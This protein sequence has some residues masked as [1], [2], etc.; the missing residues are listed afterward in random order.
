MRQ[1]DN[2]QTLF[3]LAREVAKSEGEGITT[4]CVGALAEYLAIVRLLEL[5]HKVA[6]P[7]VDDDG[8]DLWVGYS[9]MIKVQVKSAN[10][11]DSYGCLRLP[12]R[13]GNSPRMR[14]HIDVLMVFARDSGSWWII[15]M[16]FL[17]STGGIPSSLCLSEHAPA[18][19]RR[20]DDRHL[21]S[22]WF[23]AW[24]VF[25]SLGKDDD[26]PTA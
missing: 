17:K 22:E 24:W 9:P 26:P 5:G 3:N 2:Q 15:P 4:S 7:V 18:V 12:I 8:V 16:D 13:N 25:D 21:F 20:G 11:R 1:S 6:R 23:E 10:F 19:P 14:E